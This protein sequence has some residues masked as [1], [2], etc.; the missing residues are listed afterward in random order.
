METDKSVL[1]GLLSGI[2]KDDENSSGGVMLPANGYIL[3]RVSGKASFKEIIKDTGIADLY[4]DLYEQVKANINTLSSGVQTITM[5]QYGIDIGLLLW[6]RNNSYFTGITLPS[7]LYNV[8]HI[9]SCF[10]Y[11]GGNYAVIYPSK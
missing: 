11:A 7:H 1:Y 4:G 9:V 8:N 2:I 6:K 5:S 10:S 3:K